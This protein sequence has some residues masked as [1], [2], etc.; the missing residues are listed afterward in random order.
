MKSDELLHKPMMIKA[1]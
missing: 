1:W